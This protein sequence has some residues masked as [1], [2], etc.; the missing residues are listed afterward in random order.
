MPALAC[1]VLPPR[2]L[3]LAAL[4]A[5]TAFACA[6][7]PGT[8]EDPVPAD[9]PIVLR[10]L[11]PEALARRAIAYSGYRTGQSPEIQKYPNKEEIAEDLRLLARGGWT[12]LRLFDAGPHA[13]RVL[14]VIDEG[15]LDMRVML[16][17]WIS[18]AK[19]KHNASNRAEIDRAAALARAHER[20]VVAISV[21][22]NLTNPALRRHFPPPCALLSGGTSR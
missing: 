16:G 11:P 18:G 21:G 9:E 13:E 8:S 19:A 10:P 14:Q 15:G 20:T 22:N 2:S 5:L 17:I 6:A 7:T 4:T 12:F 1:P 3:V